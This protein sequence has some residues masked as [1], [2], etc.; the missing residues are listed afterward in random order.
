MYAYS[1]IGKKGHLA[2]RCFSEKEKII[3]K[4]IGLKILIYILKKLEI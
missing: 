2:V 3:L 1:K 4:Y